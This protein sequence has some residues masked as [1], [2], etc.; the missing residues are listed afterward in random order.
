ML[1]KLVAVTRAAIQ[2]GWSKYVTEPE[3]RGFAVIIFFLAIV[4]LLAVYLPHR[5]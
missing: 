3:G 2:R 1:N 5:V 4:V